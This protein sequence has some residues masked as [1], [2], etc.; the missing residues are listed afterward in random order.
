M[1]K[2]LQKPSRAKSTHEK[3]QVTVII[4]TI[5]RPTLQRAIKSVENQTYKNIE[6]LVIGE[7]GTDFELR[8]GRNWN[9]FSKGKSFGAAQRIVGTHLAT[10]DYI[11]YL[12]DDNEF[13]PDHIESLVECIKTHD[14]DFVYS[15]AHIIGSK[16]YIG[17]EYPNNGRIDTNC[18]LHKIENILI[19]NWKSDGYNAEYKL[20]TRWIKK[21]LKFNY[22]NKTTVKYYED[23]RCNPPV[24]N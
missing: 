4:P 23:I 3:S 13:L 10:G 15:K 7:G 17:D 11:A 1:R 24:P 9:K 5:G 21:G 18:I 6:I 19:S 8:L 22:L 20:V 14:V 16:K 2:D 12:D